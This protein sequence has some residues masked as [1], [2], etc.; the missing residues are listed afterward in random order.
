MMPKSIGFR[1]LN[2]PFGPS[3][4]RMSLK[5][6]TGFE[7]RLADDCNCVLITSSGAVRVELMVPAMPPARKL[8][9]CRWSAE[10]HEAVSRRP[11]IHI[12][13][14]R[15]LSKFLEPKLGLVGGGLALSEVGA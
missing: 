8:T 14:D 5:A 2:R 1:P 3:V 13:P 6:C 7:L 11:R 15:E 12:A 10:T 9:I 4:L